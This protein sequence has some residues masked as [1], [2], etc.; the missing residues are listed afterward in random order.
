MNEYNQN[1]KFDKNYPGISPN[2]FSFFSFPLNQFEFSNSIT[3]KTESNS[4]GHFSNIK[5]NREEI[6][7]KDEQNSLIKKEN[8]EEKS[9]SEN[10]KKIGRRLKDEIYEKEA[11]FLYCLQICSNFLR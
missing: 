9:N 5:R 11:K 2:N 1:D 7:N 6:E 4:L 10:N 3:G 8:S